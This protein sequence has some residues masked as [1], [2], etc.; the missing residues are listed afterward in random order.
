MS[1][2]LTYR[3]L[4]DPEYQPLPRM[5][6]EALACHGVLESPGVANNPTIMGWRDELQ[7]AGISIV[8]FS[9]DSVP[10]C[11]LF[12]ALIAHRAGKAVV[13]GPLWALNW[14]K[15]G[16]EASGGAVLGDVLIFVRNGGGH[17]AL[18]VGEDATH[19]HVIGGNQSDSV[20]FTRIAKQ[21]CVAARRPAYKIRPASAVAVALAA[22]GAVSTNEA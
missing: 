14:R 13:D 20:C 2:P 9:G 16:V 4:R 10:W 1:L 12:M 3:W 19:Y 17:V 8:G 21:R 7:E 11:G 15:F 5:V 6:A 22:S 18:Y